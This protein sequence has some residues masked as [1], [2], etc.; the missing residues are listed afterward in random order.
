LSCVIANVNRDIEEKVRASS[1]MV[2][3]TAWQAVQ[4]CIGKCI[5]IVKR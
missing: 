3:V 1:S 2:R 4:F 5:V